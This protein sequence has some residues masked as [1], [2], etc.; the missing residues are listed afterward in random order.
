MT[1]SLSP[2]DNRQQLLL[3]EERKKNAAAGISLS[4]WKL[5]QKEVSLLLH[6]RDYLILFVVFSI[7]VGFFNAILTLLNQIVEPFGYS[8]DDA[9]TFGAVFILFGLIGAGIVGKV[10][11]MTKAYKT[12]L[13]VGIVASCFATCFLLLMLFSNNFWP[14]TLG[15]ALL[16][17]CVLPLL[18]VMMENCAECTY[19]VPEEVSMGILFVG[20]KRN[21]SI[22]L[23]CLII[24][25]LSLSSFTFSVC[26]L[27]FYVFY[28]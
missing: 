19:P 24:S 6:N 20:K 23:F 11:E 3:Q 18:P 4:E 15:W 14:L 22:I 7:G 27:S 25:F 1:S 21:L 2:T 13:R 26:F 28:V 8:N 10:M 9:G 16:G 12:I 5:I 17:G